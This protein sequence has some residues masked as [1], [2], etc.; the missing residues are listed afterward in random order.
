M[1]NLKHSNWTVNNASQQNKG[2]DRI[3]LQAVGLP[4]M[5]KHL[6]L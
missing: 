1:P 3:Y 5:V 6:I 2:V 4:S